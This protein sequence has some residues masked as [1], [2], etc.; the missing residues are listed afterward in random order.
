M[1]IYMDNCCFNRP[2]D[3][4][5]NPIIYF[6]CNSVMFILEMVEKGVF[7]LCGSQM[8]VKEIEDTPDSNKRKK[9]ELIYSLCSSEIKITDCIVDRSIEIRNLSNI[10]TK[11]SI[12]LAC[13]EFAEV[14]VFLTV[15]KK[16]RNN[17]NKVP[18]KIK[19]MSP[20][21]WLMEVL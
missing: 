7:E 6:D 3:D 21:E 9:L 19:V 15:D 2:L 4:R 13:A 16:F 11:D 17:A 18:A 20:T 5:T 1:K 14:D 10:R 12:H 8:L